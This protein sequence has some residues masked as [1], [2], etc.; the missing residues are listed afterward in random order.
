MTLRD[1]RMGGFG[2]VAFNHAKIVSEFA[3][4]KIK[5]GAVSGPQHIPGPPGGYSNAD[6]HDLDTSIKR[7]RDG[8]TKGSALVV[9]TAP[10]AIYQELGTVNMEPRPNLQLAEKAKRKEF[11]EAIAKRIKENATAAKK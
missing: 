9:A 5:E 3:Q 6:T 2:N 1:F 8:G 11:K 4:K 10:H 7:Q